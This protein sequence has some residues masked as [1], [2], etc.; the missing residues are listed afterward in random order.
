[1][2]FNHQIVGSNPSDPNIKLFISKLNNNFKYK[3]DILLKDKLI[4]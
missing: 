4:Y 1:M 3:T 2:T